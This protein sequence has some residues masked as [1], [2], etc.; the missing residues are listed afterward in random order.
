LH[1]ELVTDAYFAS[2]NATST[3]ATMQLEALGTGAA[4]GTPANTLLFTNAPNLAATNGLVPRWIVNDV[5]GVNFATYVSAGSV[6][7]TAFSAY[8]TTNAPFHPLTTETPL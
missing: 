6:G 7:L 5:N 2:L 1:Y 3:G 8:N 4:F